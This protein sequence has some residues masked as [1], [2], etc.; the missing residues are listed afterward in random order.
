MLTIGLPL[1]AGLNLPQFAGVLAHEFG[2]FSQGAGMRLTY[3]IRSISFWFTRVVYERDVWDERLVAWSEGQFSFVFSL[4]RLFVWLTRKILWVLMMLGHAVGGFLLRQMEFDADRYETRL[5]GSETFE[6]TCRRLLVLNVATQGAHVDLGRFFKEGRLGDNLPKLML[7]NV[8]QIPAEVLAKL[9]TAIDESKTG[10]FD[11]HPADQERIASAR[12]E[13]AA[14]VFHADQPASVLFADFTGL[15]INV[16]LDF[17]RAIFGPQFTTIQVLP[18]ER[19]LVHQGRQV[20]ANKALRRYF[21]GQFSLLRPLHLPNTWITAPAEPKACVARL[22]AA[23]QAMLDRLAE[24]TEAY[25]EYDKADDVVLEAAQADVLI[26]VGLPVPENALGVP[27]HDCIATRQACNAALGR[28]YQ[29]EPRLAEFERAAGD[30][31]QAALELLQVPQVA[32]RLKDASRWQNEV[33]K[34]LDALV[35][36]LRHS[37]TLIELRQAHLGLATLASQLEAHG[38]DESLISGLI[39]RMGEV[40]RLVLELRSDCEAVAYPFDHA[41]GSISVGDYVLKA[42]PVEND[43]GSIYEAGEEILGSVYD[44]YARLVGRLTEI[45]EKI[46]K[47]VGLDPLPEPPERSPAENEAT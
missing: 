46:E 27:M 13:N 45:A 18:T 44:L 24:Y 4:A 20:E 1:V 40:H 32:A 38:K 23:R 16:T 6:A 34:I 15:S 2:H 14:G 28:Q 31:L 25:T 10:L 17:Y 11:T 42:L 36:V 5:A 22:K 29:A 33:Q 3:M 39:K 12:R 21:Q 35:V 26:R 43:L 7:H 9:N 41:K 19:L 47:L 30:R 8:D 37:P